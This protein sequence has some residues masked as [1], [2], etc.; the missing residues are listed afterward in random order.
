MDRDAV[1]RLAHAKWEAEGRPE[2]QHERH[3]AEAERE[4]SQGSSPQTWSS[5]HDGGVSPPTSTGSVND[6]QVEE[7]SNDWPAA[8]A[9][10]GSS[11]GSVSSPVDSLEVPQGS[12][13]K[14]LGNGDTDRG[15]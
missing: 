8:D 1:S 11:L 14:P 5:D 7:P 4:T 12:S 13:P 6:E 10:E 2:G 3:W 9:N 15:Q